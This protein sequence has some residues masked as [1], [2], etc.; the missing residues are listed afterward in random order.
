MKTKVLNNGISAIENRK[1]EVINGVKN[2]A[3]LELTWWLAQYLPQNRNKFNSLDPDQQKTYLIDRIE[4]SFAKQSE[5]FAS[6]VNQIFEAERV[7]KSITITIEWKKNST[8]GSNPTATAE[9]RFLKGG[10]SS[11]SSG[12]VSGCGYDKESTAFAQALNQCDEFIKMLYR[13]ENSEIYGFRRA[14]GEYF[15]HLSG[16]VGVSCYYSIFD[17]LGYK[18]DNTASGKTFDVYQITLND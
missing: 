10:Y 3:K 17:F 4:K 14:E 7:I 15:P 13:F 16:G 11:Y 1:N 2:S 18:M 6:R 5:K 9:I 8:W 12:S